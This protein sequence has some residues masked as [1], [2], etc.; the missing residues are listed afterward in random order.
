MGANLAQAFGLPVP[1]FQ[2]AYLADALVGAYD[3]LEASKLKSGYVFASKRI[4][5]VTELKFETIPYIAKTTR[6]E[7]LLFDLWVEHED[8]TLTELGGNPNLLWK[9]DE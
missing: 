9:P 4:P 3:G 6:L 5:S 2:L 7:V 1:E 8:R